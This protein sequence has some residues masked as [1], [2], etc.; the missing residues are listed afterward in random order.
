MSDQ[1]ESL[2]GAIVQHGPANDRIYLMKLGDA[3]PE[4]LVGALDALA[5]RHGY[6]KIFTKVP[7]GSAAPFFEAG[8]RQE[9][10]IPRFF[11][12]EETAR[13]LCLYPDPERAKEPQADALDAILSQAQQRQNAGLRKPLP[14]GAVLRSCGE[15]DA[16]VMAAIYRAVFPSYPFPIHDPAYLIETMRS[17]IVYF[18]IELHGK[19]IALA[20]SEMDEAQRNVEM[21]DFATHPD[22]LGLGLA[23]HLL[24]A[25]EKAMRERGIQTAYTIARAASP[26]MNITFARLGYAFGGRLVNNTQ[27]SG[28]IESMNIWHKPLAPPFSEPPGLGNRC[29]TASNSLFKEKAKRGLMLFRPKNRLEH[30]ILNFAASKYPHERE[31]FF[32]RP[33]SGQCRG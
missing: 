5:R 11:C 9:A 18:G 25:M 22:Q 1:I 8:Y 7:A 32:L 3:D 16:P 31:D 26:G 29:T 4:K 20:S 27:I 19:L 23:A 12:G 15:A 17:H 21:T 14:N 30:F 33:C 10:A 2:F 28:T 6:S 24:T 13:F